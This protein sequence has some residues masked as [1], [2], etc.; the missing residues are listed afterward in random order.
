VTRPIYD[1][2]HA[3]RYHLLDGMEMRCERCGETEMALKALREP[4][5]NVPPAGVYIPPR[6]ASDT[7]AAAVIASD[8]AAEAH[9]PARPRL[10]PDVYELPVARITGEKRR[11]AG[12]VALMAFCGL[13]VAVGAAQLERENDDLAAR[14]A[15]AEAERD[16]QQAEA[17]RAYA[18]QLSVNHRCV[19]TWNASRRCI[20]DALFEGGPQVPMS[21]IFIEEDAWCP[22][23]AP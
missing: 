5:F 6:F 14:L 22:A 8:A 23:E 2:V 12:F 15:T 13:T 21:G 9:R 19:L 11:T 16:Y 17:K 7:I 10:P 20:T 3:M 18:W 4:M 1:H